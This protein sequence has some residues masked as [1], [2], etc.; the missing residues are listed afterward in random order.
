[1]EDRSQA[2]PNNRVPTPK[3]RNLRRELLSIYEQLFSAYGPQHWWPGSSRFEVIVGAILTQ[4]V[5]WSNVERAI[6]SL[7]EKGLINP[8]RLAAAPIDKIATLIRPS[9]YYNAK[10]KKLHA[11]LC[12]LDERYHGDLDLLFSLDVPS[13]R[14]ELLSVSGIGKETADAI[15]LYAAGKPSFV[16]DAYTRRITSRLGLADEK[17]SY[18]EV[19]D[20]FT[21]NLPI[22]VPLYNEYHAL[23]VCHGK[24]CCRKRTPVCTNCPL[25]GSCLFFADGPSSVSKEGSLRLS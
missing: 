15:I 10:A 3:P 8:A 5:A 19:R 11:F 9:I 12:L 1:M 2:L 16:V 23:F 6:A 13:L 4:S 20:L 17:A 22:D 7:D 14:E 25:V 21:K 18:A 24:I